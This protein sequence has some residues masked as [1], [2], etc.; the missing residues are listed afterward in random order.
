M[1]DFGSFWIDE[2]DVGAAA[3]AGVGLGVKTAIERIVV[4]GLALWAHGE[5][6]HG[7]LGPVVGDAASDG[8][9]GAA[10]GAVEEGIAIA[11]VCRI[12]QF[13]KAVR[14]GGGV[15]RDAGADAAQDFAGDDTEA[16]F[17][18]KCEVGCVHGVD[19]RE[20]RD[21]GGKAGQ[22]GFDPR[23]RAFQFD[24]D[25][26]GIV[27]DKAGKMLFGGEAVDEGTESNAL[28]DTANPNAFPLK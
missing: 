10:V 27:S 19:A 8:E 14:A 25:P 21:F 20:G 3:P 16:G 9:A 2:P 5:D 23:W 1:S 13:A 4:F 7:G 15:G 18:G 24:R 6:G 22:E 28:N 26:I 12:Q 11:A 17:A